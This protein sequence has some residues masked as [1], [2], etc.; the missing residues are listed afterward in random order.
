MLS[1][2]YLK[3]NET[4][5]SL[6]IEKDASKAH[7]VWVRKLLPSDEHILKVRLTTSSPSRHEKKSSI[8]DLVDHFT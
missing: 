2:V 3:N 7:V 6:C 4:T 1:C 5:V 8:F